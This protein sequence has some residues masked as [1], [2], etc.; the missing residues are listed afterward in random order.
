MTDPLFYAKNLVI[1]MSFKRSRHS[2]ARS[3]SAR[4]YQIDMRSNPAARQEFRQASSHL[5]K[6][7]LVVEYF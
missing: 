6:M 7:N 5:L 4:V 2:S 3:M 1:R